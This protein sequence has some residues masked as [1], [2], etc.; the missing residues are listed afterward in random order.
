[1][2]FLVPEAVKSWWHGAPKESGDVGDPAE[3]SPG[4]LVGAKEKAK[5][6]FP[7]TNKFVEKTWPEQGGILKT[8]AKVAICIGAFI[9]GI[10]DLFIDIPRFLF[11]S[12]KKV[13]SGVASGASALYA[14]MPNVPFL[15]RKT[16]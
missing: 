5:V 16:E 11:W 10:V 9:T 12:G 8:A 6:V 14:K 1:M 15:H 13:C 7:I 4:R 3:S 2:S